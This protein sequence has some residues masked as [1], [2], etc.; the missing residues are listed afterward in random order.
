MKRFGRSGRKKF[1]NPPNE[2]ADNYRLPTMTPPYYLSLITRGQS[3][4]WTISLDDC[5]IPTDVSKIYERD[6]IENRPEPPI[7]GSLLTSADI[8]IAIDQLKTYQRALI[9]H[10]RE[11]LRRSIIKFKH[12]FDY[13]RIIMRYYDRLSTT[14]ISPRSID[15]FPIYVNFGNAMPYMQKRHST[16]GIPI[17]EYSGTRPSLEYTHADQT[18]SIGISSCSQSMMHPVLAAKS[19]PDINYFP[20]IHESIGDPRSSDVLRC[21]RL[22]R[23][24]QFNAYSIDELQTLLPTEEEIYAILAADCSLAI[25]FTPRR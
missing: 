3:G 20:D 5:M 1:D 13:T 24:Q 10:E 15:Y 12:G 11:V 18:M 7:I 17:S 16:G 25:S 9:D 22:L 21:E 19:L 23:R 14:V 6:V 2:I 8:E 4:V